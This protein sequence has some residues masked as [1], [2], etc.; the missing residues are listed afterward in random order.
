MLEMGL[1]MGDIFRRVGHAYPDMNGGL[2]VLIDGRN[3]SMGPGRG[4]GGPHQSG[5]YIGCHENGSPH[6]VGDPQRNGT[7]GCLVLVVPDCDVLCSDWRESWTNSGSQDR[8]IHNPPEVLTLEPKLHLVDPDVVVGPIKDGDCGFSIVG[9]G[10][11][12]SVVDGF[13]KR[14][15]SARDL[16][17]EKKLKEDWSYG[18]L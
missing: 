10:G 18:R 13:L 12:H 14:S 8:T 5:S 2:V 6:M 3:A 11:R 9:G 16:S 15:P 7:K 17:H 1:Q 4:D